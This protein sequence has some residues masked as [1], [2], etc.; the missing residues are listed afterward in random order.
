MESAPY[1][2]ALF[3]I[4]RRHALAELNNELG[5]LF[6]VDDIFALIIVFF[7]LDDL[8]TSGDLEGVVFLHPL[9]ICRYIP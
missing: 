1:S 8:G 3:N 5:D 6:N 7:I 9:P 4:C 2:H